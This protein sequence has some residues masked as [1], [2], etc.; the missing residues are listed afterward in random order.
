MENNDFLEISMV[1]REEER[2]VSTEKSALEVKRKFLLFKNVVAFSRKLP[3]S[4]VA[5]IQEG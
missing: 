3:F 1:C 4:S 2:R 5:S